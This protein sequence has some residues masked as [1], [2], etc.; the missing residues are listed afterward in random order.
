MTGKPYWL[1]SPLSFE[2]AL[3]LAT[4]DCVKHFQRDPET[5]EVKFWPGSNEV[6]EAL[7]GSMAPGIIIS[8]PDGQFQLKKEAGRSVSPLLIWDDPRLYRIEER[9]ERNPET[10]QFEGN[11]S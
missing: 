2:G 7:V 6:F 8:T 1:V 11:A 9:P 3:V 4:L 10:G 5:D